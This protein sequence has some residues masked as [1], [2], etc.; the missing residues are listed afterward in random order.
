MI[1]NIAQ[2]KIDR[3]GTFTE[4]SFGISS[5]EDL[6]YIFDILR[7]KLYSN[8]IDAVVREYSTNAADANTENG[9]RDT[10]VVI[11]CP[12]KMVPEFKV[13]DFGRG[14]SEDE[15]RNVYCMYGR[16]TKRNSN[17]YTG[18]LGLGSKSGFAYGDSFTI[19][20]YKDGIKHTY[21][22]YID[23]TRLGSIAK[24]AESK[25]EE[26]NGIEIIIPANVVDITSFE[27]SIKKCVKHFK[28][29]PNV[30]NISAKFQSD[31]AVIL[32]GD[33]WKIYD[34]ELSGY[35]HSN[36]T[37]VMGNI[38]YPVNESSITDNRN[39]YAVLRCPICVEFEIGE[40]SISANREELEYNTETKKAIISRLDKI[41]KQ[42]LKSANEQIGKCKNILEAKREFSRLNRAVN[43]VVGS[44][45]KWGNVSI[46]SSVLD[47]SPNYCKARLYSPSVKSESVQSIFLTHQS[48]GVEPDNIFIND[49]S[50]KNYQRVQHYAVTNDKQCL[51]LQFTNY[52]DHDGKTNS[53]EEWLKER[54]LSVDMFKKASDLPD[55]PVAERKKRDANVVT[56]NCFYM[57]KRND[58]RS[59]GVMSEN[60]LKGSCNKKSGGLYM[61]IDG[62]LVT[63]NGSRVNCRDFIELI[64][65]FN[66]LT[67]ES[68]SCDA[69]PCFKAADCEK[70]GK[71]WQNIDDYMTQKVLSCTQARIS[72]EANH[73]NKLMTDLNCYYGMGIFSKKMLDIL[74]TRQSEV[75]S[76]EL[77]EI[78]RLW[79]EVK[80]F[81]ENNKNNSHGKHY[82]AISEITRYIPSFMESTKS[83]HKETSELRKAFEA[84]EVKHPVISYIRGFSQDVSAI[85][86]IIDCIIKL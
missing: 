39:S 38:G 30:L 5:S 51:L 54:C 81:V 83:E 16:S 23:E 53:Y 49:G 3:V 58:V 24:I 10:P 72:C 40:L 11:T 71:N 9:K 85:N 37:F 42:I 29:K 73:A 64:S 63:F 21:T 14:L 2:P 33:G 62:F 17:E 28:V 13:R 43:Y 82:N 6:V 55:P 44:K 68:I 35:Y 74:V 50:A 20:S 86:N 19:V 47:L 25:T 56:T 78:I 76:D 32:S 8:K 59:Y 18:Q 48:K 15:I 66:K 67:G 27:N 57:K 80:K 79:I 34:G 69:I 75:K 70:L 45:L 41:E 60:F 46:D 26:L 36:A 22:A 65:N 77:K 52:V 61:K 12:T 31:E 7:S 84:M 1:S 4:S